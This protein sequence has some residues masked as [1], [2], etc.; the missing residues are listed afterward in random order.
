MTL[1]EAR[2]AMLT[3]VEAITAGVGTGWTDK[4]EPS[5]FVCSLPV[6]DGLQWT[7]EREGTIEGSAAEASAWVLDYFEAQGIEVRTRENSPSDIDVIAR[8]DDGLDVQFGSVDGG[9][10]YI[11][12]QSVCIAGS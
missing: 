2:L 12:A 3:H 6:G 7:I 5:T 10:A 11:S 1:D 9:Y 4:Y 8:A